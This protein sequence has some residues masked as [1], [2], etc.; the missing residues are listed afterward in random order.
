M[1]KLKE[2]IIS[3]T[4]RCNS[5]C[6]MC[7]IPKEIC[8]E[9]PTSSWKKMIDESFS[10]GASNIV[11]SGG[12]PLLRE[13]I[14]ELIAYT[15]DK[16]MEACITSNGLLINDKAASDLFN[17]GVNVVNI[18]I[19]GPEDIHNY[20]RGEGSHKKSISA[21]DNLRKYNIE[22][23][24]ATTVS[25]YNYK[26]LKYIVDLS[27]LKGVTTIKFQ[28][29]NTLF[30][31]DKLREKNFCISKNESIE[32][33]QIIRDVISLCDDYGI[34]TNPDAYLKNIPLYLNKKITNN[35]ACNSLW[36]SCPINSDGQIYPCW[37][38]T[39]KK[40]LIGNIKDNKITDLWGSEY[41][42]KI[43]GKIKSDGCIGCMM[44]CYDES[45][46]KGDIEK[47]ISLNIKKMKTTGIVNYLKLA[48]RRW[49]KRIKFYSTYRGS[50]ELFKEKIKKFLF[51]KK[52]HAKII[53]NKNNKEEMQRVL[54]E[55]NRVKQMLQNEIKRSK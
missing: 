15:K 16:N 47:K 34:A 6:I 17:S 29:F 50:F 1:D 9:L 54:I 35:S 36:T 43:R 37:V 26:F 31:K 51:K 24:I 7:D 20:L 4:N 25:R 30:I 42:D 38:L 21:L 53:A 12:E 45:F 27:K 18:S 46:G 49:F 5:S 41:H 8:N 28:P 2:V 44:S 23:T 40:Y 52:E 39:E 22:T 13:D 10:L 14:Y 33:E 11:F 32:L 19:E 48:N 3:I 55:I